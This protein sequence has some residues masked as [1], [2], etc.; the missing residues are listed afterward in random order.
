LK[1]VLKRERETRILRPLLQL[2]TSYSMVL[3]MPL[4]PLDDE[5]HGP[6]NVTALTRW[7]ARAGALHV[8][9]DARERASDLEP[10][11]S[12]ESDAEAMSSDEAFASAIPIETALAGGAPNDALRRCVSTLRDLV[13]CSWV[14]EEIDVRQ[15]HCDALLMLGRWNEL[16][17]ASEHLSALAASMPSPRY[18]TEA[19]FFLAFDPSRP[20]DWGLLEQ[21]ATRI[22]CAPIAAR[23]AR[24]LL[25]EDA[26]L[27]AVDRRVFEALRAHRGV[28]PATRLHPTPP[29]AGSS[30]GPGWGLADEHQQVWRPD[31][32]TVSLADRPQLWNLLVALFE[33]GGDVPR[34]RLTRDLWGVSSLDPRRFDNHLRVAVRK[35]RQVVEDE[36]SE[37]TRIVTTARGYALGGPV[38][39]A[40]TER[41]VRA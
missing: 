4:S 27:D 30:S 29:D 22:H 8:S 6:W 36:P 25:G 5:F 39:R 34:E 13:F 2:E 3:A 38:R 11:G 24:A 17:Q 19:R 10:P 35:L 18:Q 32:T 28:V 33:H 23:R 26:R 1:P 20:V 7:R 37:P 21:L 16:A 12:Q 14:T 9:Q 15:L 40:R 41:T 31:G